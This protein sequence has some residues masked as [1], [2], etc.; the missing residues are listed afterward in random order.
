MSTYNERILKAIRYD[1]P[2][3]IPIHIAVMPAVWFKYGAELEK[4]AKDYPDFIPHVPD[5]TNPSTI[6][7][8]T[9]HQGTHTDEW[10]CIWSNIEEGLEAIVTGH[11]L[12]TRESV[13][14]LQIPPNRDGR[15]PHG[16]M[17]LRLMDLRGFEE[18]M[19]D[20]AEECEELQILIDKVTEYNCLQVEAVLPRHEKGSVVRLGDDLGMQYTLAIGPEKWRKYLKP[21]FTKIYA[22]FKAKGCYV[23]MHTD[24]F[25]LDIINDLVECGVDMLNAQSGGNGTENLARICKGRVPLDFD[26]DRQLLPVATPS[27]IE[28]HIREC[29]EAFYMPAGG[30]AMVAGIN[31]DVP[32]EN[33]AALF[34]AMRKY[35]HGINT[36]I[37]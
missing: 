29:V 22:P 10:G 26:V 6:M 7:G 8:K 31:Q 21:A 18:M 25:V 30:L 33:M 24:G 27:Q 4:L 16:F 19:I 20:F 9:Y 3:E 11:P 12:P 5:Y 37:R 36:T 2:D 28:S 1:Y 34:D 17:Y 13:R 23:Y 15:L 35:K 32:L 14:A